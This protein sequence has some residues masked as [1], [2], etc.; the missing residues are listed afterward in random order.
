MEV[1]TLDSQVYRNL[2]EKL[3]TIFQFVKSQGTIQL[4]ES[5]KPREKTEKGIAL[6]NKDVCKLLHVSLRTLN[7]I[8]TR[9]EITYTR[10]GGR[11]RYNIED[12]N[13]YIAEGKYET[14]NV[15]AQHNHLS[16]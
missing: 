6:D 12:V 14:V 8:R 7:R 13:K 10:I 9:G 11:I 1:V 2:V 4:N 5:E 3:E 15:I 16:I